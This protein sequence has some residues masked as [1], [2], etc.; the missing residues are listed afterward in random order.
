MHVPMKLIPLLL[1]NFIG[2]INKYHS[3]NCIYWSIKS[4]TQITVMILSQPL[5]VQMV[6]LSLLA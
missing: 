2:T 6:E 3:L 5:T 1:I 4:L